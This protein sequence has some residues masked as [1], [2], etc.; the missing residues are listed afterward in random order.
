ME[1]GHF[2]RKLRPKERDLLESVLPPDRA[3]YRGYREFLRTALVIAEGRRGAGNLVLGAAATVPDLTA[4][5]PPVVAYGM[6][7]TTRD[8]FSITLREP[9]D[10]QME[11]EIVSAHGQEIP[12]HFE[13][14]RRWSYSL[15]SPGQ[16][17]PATGASVREV[18]VG[19]DH[20]L[21]YAPADKRLWIH[22]RS[23]GLN[24]LLP[25]TAFYHELMAVRRVR[26]PRIAL[27]TTLL[28][29]GTDAPSENELRE[30]FLAYN[31]ERRRV[32]VS[33]TAKPER[34]RGVLRRLIGAFRNIFR[35][36]S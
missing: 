3:G 35:H 10:E 24:L 23:T 19:S 14:K 18:G 32:V 25:A 20:V 22:E 8:T 29:E 17:S 2:P 33:E 31:R 15:W 9:L 34:P 28:F 21:V 7:E 30:A 27:Q 16:A 13:E 1:G 4:P 12:D 6:V 36:T 11:A 5:L 26:D